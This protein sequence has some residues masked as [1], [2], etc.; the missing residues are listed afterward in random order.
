MVRKTNSMRYLEARRI[1]YHAYGFSSDIRSAE[2]AARAMGVPA[3]AVYKTLVVGREHGR[4][5]LVMIP[6]DRALDLKRLA[7][8]VGE[9]KLHMA[10]HREAECLTGLEVGG[11]SALS[12]IQKGFEVYADASIA[13]QSDVH[14]SA[15]CRGINLRLR[16]EDLLR[17]TQARVAPL[18]GPTDGESAP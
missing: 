2:D 16:A 12:L 3:C 10:T 5:L 8:A 7:R 15:G 18:T 9:K 13:E 4:P 6:G 14:V 11:I 1:P 17:V